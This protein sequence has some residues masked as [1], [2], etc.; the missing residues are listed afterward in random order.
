MRYLIICFLLLSLLPQPLQHA[1]QQVEYVGQ[2]Q[3]QLEIPPC[4]IKLEC[5]SA[6]IEQKSKL[7]IP[8]SVG[9]KVF[10][11][12]LYW[13]PKQGVAGVQLVLVEPEK[14]PPFIYVDIDQNGTLS[15][16]ER[17][18]FSA[19]R[20]SP[21]KEI[22]NFPVRELADGKA[23]VKFPMPGPY[24]FY[25]VEVYHYETDHQSLKDNSRVLSQ[26][27]IA[28]LRGYVDIKG[29]KTLVKY[30]LDPNTGEV[31]V[32]GSHPTWV[33]I[34]INGDGQIG[35]GLFSLE[36]DTAEGHPIIFRIGED[37][38]STKMVDTRTGK[39]VFRIHP[40]SDY[41]RVELYLGAEMPDFPFIDFSGKAHRVSEFRGK[42][43]L[44]DY[45]A[46]WCK[47][48][49]EEIPYLKQAYKNYQSRGLEILGM[50]GDSDPSKAK[51]TVA[52]KQVMWTQAT[53]ESIQELSER[54]LGI[55]LFPTT[56]LLDAQGKIVSLGDRGH[57]PLRGK[58]LIET[59]DKLLAKR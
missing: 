52:Q 25:P 27:C 38:I 19:W 7:A 42:Y 16:A 2:L 1:Q 40:A 33:G 53:W 6:T 28:S 47:P 51:E 10:V 22:E 17:F 20:G 34:D 54:R 58:E 29:Q 44:L 56:I 37:Y 15:A 35:G 14:E 13:P 50:N 32:K 4:L 36:S 41:Q 30:P 31:E 26:T 21:F 39:V 11:D 46:T 49:I 3:P 5:K 48:C 12:K 45:W 57:L 8:L 23:V 24:K 9:D 43:L 18:T 55:R 59:L